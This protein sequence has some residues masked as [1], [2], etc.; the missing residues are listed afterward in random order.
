M[1]DLAPPITARSPLHRPCRGHPGVSFEATWTF[2]ARGGQTL[3]TGRMVFPSAAARELVIKEYGA[4]E[5]A[6]QTFDR[7]E[8]QL[9]KILR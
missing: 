1:D 5:G 2:E 9:I 7:L 6:Q 4:I 8:E 3:L